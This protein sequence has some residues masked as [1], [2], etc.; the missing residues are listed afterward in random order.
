MVSA[1][2]C[3]SLKYSFIY[4]KPQLNSHFLIEILIKIPIYLL[5]ELSQGGESKQPVQHRVN[6]HRWPLVDPS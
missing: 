1:G 6:N 2:R 4:Y 3:S 5:N